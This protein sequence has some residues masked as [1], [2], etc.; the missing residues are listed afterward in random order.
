MKLEIASLRL[1]DCGPFEDVTLDFCDP[2]SNPKKTILLAGANGSGKTT[3]LEA[4]SK[5][6]SVSLSPGQQLD[7][8]KGYGQLSIRTDG[9]LATLEFGV[10]RPEVID[11]PLEPERDVIELLG[12]MRTGLVEERQ[13][14]YPP[15]L[16]YFPHHHRQLY[17]T[18]AEF[19]HSE[20]F[21]YTPVFRYQDSDVFPGSLASYLIWLEY[22]EP[23]EYQANLRFLNELHVGG[24]TFGIVRK[25]LQAVV[26]T[27]E[28]ATHPIEEMSSGEQQLFII[29][30][31]LRR[32]LTKGSIVL[33]DE[34]EE[35]LHPAYQYKLIYALEKLQEEF[36]LQ[37]IMTTHSADVLEA[38][39]AQNTLILTDYSK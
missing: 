22:A 25:K 29:L 21:R 32:R 15:T 30:L 39:G 12:K 1:V 18:K 17:S 2:S 24:K 7:R 31:E 6:I 9:H 5:A 11:R 36:D 16:L 33:I 23:E 13:E 38:V 10:P 28:G 34:V 19:L 3:V 20:E 4:I 8:P 37:L 35:S 14:N 27:P 26:T